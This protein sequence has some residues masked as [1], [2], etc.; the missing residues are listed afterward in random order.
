MNLKLILLISAFVVALVG[1]LVDYS[2]I[3]V[4][5]NQHLAGLLFLSIGCYFAHLLAPNR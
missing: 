2:V 1:F 3:D 4:E 5:G